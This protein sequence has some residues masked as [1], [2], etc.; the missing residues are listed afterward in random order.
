MYPVKKMKKWHEAIP[1]DGTGRRDRPIQLSHVDFACGAAGVPL[2]CCLTGPRKSDALFFGCGVYNWMS[3]PVQSG[4]TF[5]RLVRRE[6]TR[7]VFA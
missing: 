7:D 3:Y 1:S 4:V 2:A 6:R 5:G